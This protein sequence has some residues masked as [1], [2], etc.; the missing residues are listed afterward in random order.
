M[1]RLRR[2]RTH[3]SVGRWLLHALLL[4]FAVR[5]LVPGGVMLD[6]A[7]S[8]GD[9]GLVLCTGHGPLV[10]ST[11]VDQPELAVTRQS[12]DPHPHAASP[13]FDGHSAFQLAD[14]PHHQGTGS[15]SG[16]LCP[17]AGA[18]TIALI[19]IAALIVA[20]RVDLRERG[21]SAARTRIFSR[22]RAAAHTPRAP[23]AL[24]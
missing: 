4:L 21:P 22:P 17:F 23:P 14:A 11:V 1:N 20:H 16:D 7:T 19:A 5:L 3:H 2:L 6:D 15:A 24:A 13:A 10:I 18:L 9:F 12:L 8:D